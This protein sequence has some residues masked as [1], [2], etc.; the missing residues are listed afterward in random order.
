MWLKVLGI[1]WQFT[2]IRQPFPLEFRD[3]PLTTIQT[4]S[5]KKT[6]P[7]HTFAAISR[8]QILLSQTW[9]SMRQPS[10]KSQWNLNFYR[11]HYSLQQLIRVHIVTEAI[12]GPK[13]QNEKLIIKHDN[14]PNLLKT[15]FKINM[16]KVMM[17]LW[18]ILFITCCPSCWQFSSAYKNG[19]QN[20]YNFYYNF[21]KIQILVIIKW[22]CEVL[23]KNF[24]S[25][26]RNICCF[27]WTCT[28]FN[29][30]S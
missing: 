16:I 8:K 7:Y 9:L 14:W 22:K 20:A 3:K 29:L 13:I 19:C 4:V 11:S 23:K 25:F 2:W 17:I 30:I 27:V 24:F 28:C 26:C 10:T 21:S 6:T 12:K 1:K 18:K 15:Y 5:F